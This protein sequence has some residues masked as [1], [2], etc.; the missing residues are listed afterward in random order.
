MAS[1]AQDD[2]IVIDRL[3]D[4]ILTLKSPNAVFAVWEQKM[5]DIE[6]ESDSNEEEVPLGEKI[7]ESRP[8]WLRSRI[9]TLSPGGNDID[10]QPDTDDGN[11]A[12][13]SIMYRVSSRHLMSGSAKFRNELTGP[14]DESS[15][16]KDGMYHLNTSEWDIEAFA[17]FLNVLHLRNRQ[18]PKALS[19]EM[20]A[21]VAVLVDYYRCW[22]AF[23]LFSILWVENVRGKEPVPGAYMREL[24]LWM[25]V[26]WVFRL[27]YEFMQT[28][29]I[30]IRQN[31]E[32]H[33]RDMELGI[34]PA[35]L[36]KMSHADL[37]INA[38]GNR[39]A[40]K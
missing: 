39:N 31:K 14:W 20:L 24:M 32:P 16:K 6:L 4:T 26:S 3:G 5:P 7:L 1:S 25:V 40:G 34:P 11:G 38:D 27:P 35:I 21:K 37:S 23:D 8:M 9:T 13:P 30:A 2:V 19:L 29:R 12:S 17:I 22:E 33:I 10:S 18:V 15:K 36:S 28:T